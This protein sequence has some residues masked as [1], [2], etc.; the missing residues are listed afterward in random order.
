MTAAAMIAA[1]QDAGGLE[2]NGTTVL[3]A[4]LGSGGAGL[5]LREIILGIGKMTRGVAVK[6]STRKDDLVQARDH[7]LARAVAAELREDAHKEN[8]EREVRNRRRSD[9]RAARMERVLILN[10]LESAIPAEGILEDTITPAQMREI[11]R[12]GTP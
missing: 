6:E 9:A 4:A 1:A 11:Q 3:V 8:F 2:I 7:A 5:M 12:G 10:G